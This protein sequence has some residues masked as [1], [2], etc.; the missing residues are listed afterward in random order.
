M[1]AAHGAPTIAIDLLMPASLSLYLD[2]VRFL[3]ALAVLLTLPWLERPASAATLGA[4]EVIG[5]DCPLHYD[6]AA[7]REHGYE[8]IVSPVSMARVWALVRTRTAMSPSL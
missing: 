1:A 5:W 8:S 4:P 2:L 6:K 7:A 3:A